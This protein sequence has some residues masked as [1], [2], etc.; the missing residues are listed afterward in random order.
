MASAG[1]SDADKV[2][3]IW[4]S[5]TAQLPQKSEQM[6]QGHRR[7][8][9]C[10][11]FSPD[12][13][14]ILASGDS[15]TVKLWNVEQEVCI[16]NFNHEEAFP[17]REHTC[18]RSMFFYPRGDEGHACVF[19]REDTTLIRMCLDNP[20]RIE[21][22]IR[23]MLF[24]HSQVQTSA[25]SP[26]GSLLALAYHLQYGDE[27]VITLCS[28]SSGRIASVLDNVPFG[29]CMRRHDAFLAFSPDGKYL[30]K[31]L[32]G[33]E[34]LVFRGLHNLSVKTQTGLYDSDGAPSSTWAVAFDPSGEFMA[35]AG[36][37]QSFRL[38]KVRG[39]SFSVV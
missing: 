31:D 12:D 19:L 13:S 9:E 5:N 32:N 2:I 38:W 22:R 35:T 11:D 8:I 28:L 7:S 1:G 14:N 3:R 17:L 29:D 4:P 24:L 26:C 20:S 10:L 27:V 34:I 6:L 18:I 15:S 39:L 23:G 16:H 36:W 30:V 21:S 33:S 25:F 37:D